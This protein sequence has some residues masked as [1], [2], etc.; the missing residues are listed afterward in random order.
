VSFLA[1]SPTPAALAAAVILSNTL[2]QR[3]EE[4]FAQTISNPILIIAVA[5]NQVDHVPPHL[6]ILVKPFPFLLRF[7]SCVKPLGDV[8]VLDDALLVNDPISGCFGN[9]VL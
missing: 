9:E 5:L 4:F 7:Q 6:W 3:S 1:D 2:V 8:N